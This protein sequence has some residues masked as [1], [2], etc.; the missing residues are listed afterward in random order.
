MSSKETFGIFEESVKAGIF[1]NLEGS[2]VAEC[3]KKLV[4]FGSVAG[5]TV[6]GGSKMDWVP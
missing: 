3:F 1:G 2:I 6:G 5:T 4:G